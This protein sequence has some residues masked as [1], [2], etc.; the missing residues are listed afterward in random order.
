MSTNLD[1]GIPS[2]RQVGLFGATNSE[3]SEYAGIVRDTDDYF[4]FFDRKPTDPVSG[5]G[6]TSRQKVEIGAIDQNTGIRYEQLG[7]VRMGTIRTNNLEIVSSA[8]ENVW[9][10]S[11]GH[12]LCM[13]VSTVS[14]GRKKTNIHNI[15]NALDSVCSLQG[16][17]YEW[18]DKKSYDDRT[19]HGFI[20]QDVEKVLPT[21]VLTDESGNKSVNYTEIIPVLTNAIKEL[22]EKM[23]S[24]YSTIQ[25][26]QAKVA[27]KNELP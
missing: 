24:M 25:E 22:T 18:K 20:A 17:E 10:Y 19:H 27:E 8:G 23:S 1:T 21:A 13:S 2:D 26:L 12:I 15:P 16:V 11:N 7:N 3:A 6:G 4:Y 9:D 14:D 5:V